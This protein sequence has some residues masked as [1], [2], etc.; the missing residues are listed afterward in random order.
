MKHTYYR[1]LIGEFHGWLATRKRIASQRQFQNIEEITSANATE[2]EKREI[3]VLEADDEAVAAWTYHGQVRT[4]TAKWFATSC[5][6]AH[7]YTGARSEAKVQ[8]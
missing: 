8:P 3:A 5:T 2:E 7:E 6:P 1:C 4:V